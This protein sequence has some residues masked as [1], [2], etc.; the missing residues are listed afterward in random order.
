MPYVRVRSIWT[1]SSHLSVGLPI[2][3]FSWHIPSNILYICYFPITDT[4]STHRIL[5]DLVTPIFVKSTNY[6]APLYAASSMVL[7]VSVS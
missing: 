5:L 3:L 4:R 6:E 1:F 7:L 2:D